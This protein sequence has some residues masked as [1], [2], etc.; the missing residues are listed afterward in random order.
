MDFER[1]Y[2]TATFYSPLED[3]AETTVEVEIRED[4]L[5]GR[6]T[7]IVPDSFLEPEET[8]DLPDSVTDS[9]GCFFC[10]GTVGEATPEYPDF[11]GF[12]RGSVGEATSFP[13][14]NPYATHSNVVVLTEDHYVPIGDLSAEVLADGLQA[15]LEYVDRVFEH[16]ST[17]AVASVNMNLLPAAGSSIIHPHVQAIVDDR[18]T[19]SQRAR[20]EGATAYRERVGS[21]YFEDLLEA[22]RDTDRYVGATGAVEWIAPFAPRHQRHVRGIAP[23]VGR[24]E[25]ESPI[26][27]SFA[28]GIERVLAHYADTG[29]NSFNFGLH[30][31]ADEAV[32]PHLDVVARSA[33]EEYAWSDATFFETIHDESMIDVAPEAY[34]ESVAAFF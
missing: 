21:D 27:E 15:A 9:E 23:E 4:P 29:L 2:Q 28:D 1:E 13:N 30:L 3:F 16:D 10:P 32:R 34:A 8:P 17:A 33:F 26:V 19:N 25:P 20:L 11:V 12:D 18:G 7:R 31:F 22:T 6:Q 24:L 5:T 14:L